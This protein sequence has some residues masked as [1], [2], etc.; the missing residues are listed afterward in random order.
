MKREGQGQEEEHHPDHPVELPRALVGPGE[1]HPAHV[2]EHHRHHAV[3]RPAVGVAEEHPEGHRELDVLHA[4]VGGVGVGDVVQHQR[5]PG[6]GEDDEEI[7]AD[8]PQAQG[9]LEAEDVDAHP[10]RVQVQNHATRA[11]RPGAAAGC[12]ASRCGRRSGR[13]AARPGA[14]AARPPR[15]SLMPEP[16]VRSH[17]APGVHDQLAPSG[18]AHGEARQGPGGGALRHVTVLV[19]GA[20]VARAGE[21]VPLLV[22]DVA[23]QVGADRGDRVESPDGPEDEHPVV[24]QEGHAVRRELLGTAHREAPRG[25]VGHVGD[26]RAGQG[27]KETDAAGGETGG[28]RGEHEA[29]A[30]GLSL[31]AR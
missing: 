20:A 15:C 12:G 25:L 23:P 11:S 1:E 13:L 9:G 28:P 29:A 17:D 4:P 18:E 30:R 6:D 3:G 21:A 2:E 27:Q 24:G 14:A 26:H 7:E 16:E 10:G 5:Q 31:I 8:Q 22:P 19:E